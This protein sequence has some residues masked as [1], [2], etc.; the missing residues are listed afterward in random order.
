MKGT[1][2][3]THYFRFQIFLGQVAGT[4]AGTRLFDH[5]GW[6]AAAAFSLALFVFQIFVLL[7]RGPHC[8]RYTWVG[9][10]G[11]WEA[12]KGVI[13]GKVEK[14]KDQ[15]QGLEDRKDGRNSDDGEVVGEKEGESR[16]ANNENS[17]E[18]KEESRKSEESGVGKNENND[19]TYVESASRVDSTQ[20]HEESNTLR[21]S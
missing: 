19:Q 3:T 9:F 17:E 4:A 14:E 7:A 12:R 10:E 15:E 8:G 2:L 13:D 21:S 5:N 18:V 16:M 11:G 6:R 20:G 1:F